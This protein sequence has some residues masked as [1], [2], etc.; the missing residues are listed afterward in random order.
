MHLQTLEIVQIMCHDGICWSDK[1]FRESLCTPYLKAAELGIHELVHE[2]LKAYFYSYIFVD[3]NDH[4][5][6]ELAV[7]NRQEKVFSLVKKMNLYIWD[8]KSANTEDRANILHL[9]AKSA[10]SSEISGAALQMQREL[11]WFKVIHF[12]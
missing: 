3:K 4:C 10:S 8:W 6:F 7:L 9:V 1:Q 11:Q 12:L 2:I 5:I